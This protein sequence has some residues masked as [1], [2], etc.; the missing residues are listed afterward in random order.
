MRKRNRHADLAIELIKELKLL[1][2]I[3]FVA[4]SVDFFNSI[5]LQELQD[6][7]LSFPASP[8]EILINK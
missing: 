6:V 7:V 3:L 1:S 4:D 5:S 8:N 2:H